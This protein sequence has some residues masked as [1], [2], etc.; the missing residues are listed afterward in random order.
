MVCV[1]VS[2]WPRQVHSF[3]QGWLKTDRSDL[4]IT[5]AGG[6]PVSQLQEG[7]ANRAREKEAEGGRNERGRG[8]QGGN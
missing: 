3:N 2:Q 1:R 5:L 7:T 8:R 6:R 4:N